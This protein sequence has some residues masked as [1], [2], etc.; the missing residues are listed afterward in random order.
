MK[1]RNIKTGAVVNAYG[2]IK[3]DAW[4]PIPG[5]PEV[6]KKAEEPAEKTLDEKKIAKGRTK[7][8]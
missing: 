7:R 6:S 2:T 3:G 4:E 8:K 1:Y 5:K